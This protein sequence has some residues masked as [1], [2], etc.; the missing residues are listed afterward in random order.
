MSKRLQVEQKIVNIII[1]ECEKEVTIRG[2]GRI[3][4]LAKCIMEK[5][6]PFKN[7]EQRILNKAKD[8]CKHLFGKQKKLCS[9]ALRIAIHDWMHECYDYA[10][11]A[12]L[13]KSSRIISFID[14]CMVSKWETE[15][16]NI[17]PT[18]I[19]KPDPSLHRPP[20]NGYIPVQAGFPMGSIGIA[21]LLLGI[22][23]GIYWFTG[24]KKK[25][26]R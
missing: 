25:K 2:T 1:K 21:I 23:F 6:K 9:I 14:K 20:G 24:R 26:R 15:K 8:A 22:G 4:Q 12:N 11:S 3:I 17:V 18:L 7:L 5:R 19:H 16:G 10:R 13:N